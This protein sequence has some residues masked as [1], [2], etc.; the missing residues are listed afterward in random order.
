M[1]PG[2]PARTRW[3]WWGRREI[4]AVEGGLVLAGIEHRERVA[5]AGHVHRHAVERGLIGVHDRDVQNRE[6]RRHE[7]P[8][9]E[10]QPLRTR[11]LEQEF[12]V[13]R[14]PSIV[15]SIGT[16]T[17]FPPGPPLRRS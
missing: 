14:L 2:R 11:P 16:M 15:Y 5:A 17:W 10:E 3:P 13:S 9:M 12:R 4:L 6:G 8:L 7:G 1:R